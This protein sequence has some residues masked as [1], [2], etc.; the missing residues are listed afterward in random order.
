MRNR[1]LIKFLAAATAT[2]LLTTS[3]LPQGMVYASAVQTEGTEAV[4]P[5]EGTE[6]PSEESVEGTEA[7]TEE[8]KTEMSTE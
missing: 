2:A 3:I 4:M 6:M 5:E 7:M 1:K 8:P